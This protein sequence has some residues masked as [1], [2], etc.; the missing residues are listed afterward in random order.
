MTFK[1]FYLK[2]LH[3]RELMREGLPE[4]FDEK[5]YVSLG[6]VSAPNKEVLYSKLQNLD[7]N[8]VGDIIGIDMR[9]MMVGDVICD[10]EINTYFICDS[11]G[12]KQIE[13]E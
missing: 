2:N 8:T 9:S 5:K 3:H 11:W 13:K 12:W 6:H 1:V 4:T 10:T 7:G